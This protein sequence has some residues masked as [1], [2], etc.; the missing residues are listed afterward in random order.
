MDLIYPKPNARISIPRDLDGKM[1]NAVFELAH[2][3]PMATVF[4]HLDG[5]YIGSTRKTH[6]LAVNPE[7]GKHTLTVIDENGEMLEQS[8]EVLSKM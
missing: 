2:R 1:G 8:F 4:W 3:N 6:H 5:M 7:Q